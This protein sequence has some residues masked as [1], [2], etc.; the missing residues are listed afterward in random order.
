MKDKLQAS[1][2]NILGTQESN[3]YIHTVREVP[4]EDWTQEALDVRYVAHGS[5]YYR[6]ARMDGLVW[7]NKDKVGTIMKF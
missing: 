6:A 4:T 7:M 1:L 5:P 2:A 3:V